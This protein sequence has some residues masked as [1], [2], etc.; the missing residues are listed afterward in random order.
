MSIQIQNTHPRVRTTRG[1]AAITRG[2]LVYC[3]ESIDNPDI[4]IFEAEIDPDSLS[5]G[6][7][8]L[9]DGIKLILG[10]TVDGKELTLLFMG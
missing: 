4:N 5:P 7:S 2:P 10:K 6:S 8:S 3:L 1:K 9:F